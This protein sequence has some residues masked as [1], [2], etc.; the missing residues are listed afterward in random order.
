MW[1]RFAGPELVTRVAGRFPRG[2]E[3]RILPTIAF[4]PIHWAKVHKYFTDE[5]PEDQHAVWEQVPPSRQREASSLMNRLLSDFFYCVV[6]RSF[7]LV[8]SL[9][10]NM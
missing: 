8:D 9:M 2:A 4:Y 5:D 7:D 10:H 3:L 6:R 1:G